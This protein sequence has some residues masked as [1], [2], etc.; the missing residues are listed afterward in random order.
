M[1]GESIGFLYLFKIGFG[2]GSLKERLR[3][4]V[5]HTDGLNDLSGLCPNW[6]PK[7]GEWKCRAIFTKVEYLHNTWEWFK[8]NLKVDYL[9]F[10]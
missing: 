9:M 7:K 5:S 6:N 3:K 4:W 1:G 2:G 10:F 8:S